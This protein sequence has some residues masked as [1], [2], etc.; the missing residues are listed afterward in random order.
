MDKEQIDALA[1]EIA[2]DMQKLVDFA[3]GLEL[4]KRTAAGDPCQISES[5]AKSIIGVIQIQ[6]SEIKRL[7]A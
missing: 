4:L 1:E 7:K 3:Q 2:G 6:S 5:Q